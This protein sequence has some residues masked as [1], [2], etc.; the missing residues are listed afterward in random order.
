MHNSIVILKD[1]SLPWQGDSMGAVENAGFNAKVQQNLGLYFVT[2]QHKSLQ[3]LGS[4]QLTVSDMLT[5][6]LS[7]MAGWHDLEIAAQALRRF[8]LK[9]RGGS[10]WSCLQSRSK[11]LT[12]TT[13]MHTTIDPEIYLTGC[14]QKQQTMQ[15]WKWRCILQGIANYCI[16]LSAILASLQCFNA[17][18]WASGRASNL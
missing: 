6:L 1:C 7:H 10:G 11:S 8:W 5:S 14:T 15:T 2:I 4:L 18:G 12:Q 16:G 3:K 9:Q 13:P 17:V